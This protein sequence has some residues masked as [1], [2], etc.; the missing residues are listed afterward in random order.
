MHLA[1]AM[2]FAGSGVDIPAIQLVL[3]FAFVLFLVFAALYFNLRNGHEFVDEHW[4]EGDIDDEDWGYSLAEAKAATRRRLAELADRH[5][6]G[7]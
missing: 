6:A 3:F 5:D 4:G 1:V 2:D 7:I